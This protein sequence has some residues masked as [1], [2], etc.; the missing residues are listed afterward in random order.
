MEHFL[1]WHSDLV[2]KD[3]A[4][5]RFSNIFLCKNR[6]YLLMKNYTFAKI[7]F[8]KAKDLRNNRSTNNKSQINS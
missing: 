3:K 2:I 8:T 1:S 6:A 4:Q 7:K 5:I